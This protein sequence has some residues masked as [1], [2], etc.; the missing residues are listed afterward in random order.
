VFKL[1]GPF[2]PWSEA[3][4]GSDRIWVAGFSVPGVSL[5]CGKDTA[6]CPPGSTTGDVLSP[7]LGFR[8]KA[9]QHLTSVQIDQSGNLWLSNNWANLHKTGGSGVV[10][11]VGMATP[12]CTPLIGQ[13]Q[14]PSAATS[15]ACPGLQAA[16]A[17]AGSGGGTS[18][19]IWLAVAAV[20]LAVVAGIG[21]LLTR[22]RP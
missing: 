18:P 19:W 20:T 14:K 3:I 13:P 9:M 22:K 6:V 2:S 11:L 1:P 17:T 7:R 4:D 10:E 15:T 12:V 8:S 16:S 5:L 21:L